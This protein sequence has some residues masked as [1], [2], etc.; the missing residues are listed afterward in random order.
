[1]DEQFEQA[2]R[3]L[4]Q[5]TDALLAVDCSD[6]AKLDAVLRRRAEAIE[7][8]VRLVERGAVVRDE[9]IGRSAP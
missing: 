1:M 9:R 3:E 8:V 6:L 5:T 7:R 4:E 2:I